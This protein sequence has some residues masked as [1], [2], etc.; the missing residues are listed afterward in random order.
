[1]RTHLYT[2]FFDPRKAFHTV[3]RH[4][5]WEVMYEVGC[6]EQFTHMLR[7]LH[8]GM[9]A[10]VTDYGTVSEAIAV[11]NEVKQGCVLCPPSLVS[12]SLPC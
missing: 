10:H 5:L 1:M 7:Q 9:M 3:N 11:T 8:D 2:T 12:C 6:P 4:G